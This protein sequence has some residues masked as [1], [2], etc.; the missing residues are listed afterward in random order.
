[1]QTN[2]ICN[3]KNNKLDDTNT[4]TH[5]AISCKLN[6]VT[7]Q[8]KLSLWRIF[9]RKPEK[10]KKRWRKHKFEIFKHDLVA[11]SVLPLKSMNN[12]V[13]LSSVSTHSNN[14]KNYLQKYPC[15]R[16][17]C[18]CR[19]RIYRLR[20]AIDSHRSCTHYLFFTILMKRLI[21]QADLQPL[22]NNSNISGANVLKIRASERN[23]LAQWI[24]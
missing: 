11:D 10:V 20:T 2:K 1:M 4:H 19:W 14:P 9:K 21:W 16:S 6:F 13:R 8:A 17:R 18:R 22:E 3:K 5:S 7:H 12:F 24:S 23:T 15:K